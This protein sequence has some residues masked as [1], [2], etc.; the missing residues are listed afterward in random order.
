MTEGI[1][2]GQM[3][4]LALQKIDR[5]IS[6]MARSRRKQSPNGTAATTT[7]ASSTKTS[8]NSNQ[9][10]FERIDENML[11]PKNDSFRY[12]TLESLHDGSVYCARGFL[13]ASEC[14]AWINFMQSSAVSKVSH[15]ASRWIAH[16]ECYRWQRNDWWSMA[17]ALFERL[18]PVLERDI[19]APDLF[20]FPPG[21]QP[22]GCNGNIRLYKYEKSMSFGRHIDESN[23]TVRGNTE[24]TVL[25]YLSDCQGGATRF[26]PPTAKRRRESSFAFAPEAG[27]ILLHVHGDRC[28]EHEADPVEGGTKYVLRTDLVFGTPPPS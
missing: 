27:A 23:Q 5:K 15:P 26:Y 6:T 19:V 20:R 18:R 13:S 21:Y 25:V 10:P 3:R 4:A 28:L 7:K 9:N 2:V 16:R 8:K 12:Q 11:N 24:V 1:S 17:D 14:R 22:V